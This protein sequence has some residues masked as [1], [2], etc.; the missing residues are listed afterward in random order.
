MNRHRKVVWLFLI[1]SIASVIVYQIFFANFIPSYEN[2]NSADNPATESIVLKEGSY[3]VGEDFNPGYYDVTCLSS[4]ASSNGFD[5]VKNEKLLAY[6]Y[7]EQNKLDIVEGAVRLEAAAFNKIFPKNENLYELKYD[8]NYV[9]GQEIPIGEYILNVEAQAD[10]EFS[11]FVY[12]NV[13]KSNTILLIDNYN[14]DEN[15][16]EIISLKEGYL[17]YAMS[18]EAV[19]SLEFKGE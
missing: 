19:F 1:V 3:V 7:F 12:G 2:R 15:Q 18:K 5:L 13:G 10:N 11:F 16:N 8:G 9:V 4:S 17:I 14:Y 6:T